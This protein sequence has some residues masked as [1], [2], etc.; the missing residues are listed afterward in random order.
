VVVPEPQPQRGDGGWGQRP[1]SALPAG[2]QRAPPPEDWLRRSGADEGA[3]EQQRC[4]VAR[5]T[6][7]NL[8]VAEFLREFADR[9]RPVL[10]SGGGVTADWA[11]WERWVSRNG[12]RL[13]RRG[14]SVPASASGAGTHRDSVTSRCGRSRARAC[15]RATVRAPDSQST[16]AA[17]HPPMHS[18]QIDKRR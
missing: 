9:N 18:S 2:Q 10:I 15:W 12:W 13:S 11:A 6:A 8:T 1:A 16:A 5:R 14:R 7:A 3:G 17:T 4:D